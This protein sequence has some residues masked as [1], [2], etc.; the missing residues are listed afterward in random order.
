MTPTFTEGESNSRDREL[1]LSLNPES[2]T[3]QP[4]STL[5]CLLN[6]DSSGSLSGSYEYHIIISSNAVN[7]P[8]LVIPVSVTV[9]GTPANIPDAN[10]RLAINDALGQGPDYQPTVQDLESLT[11]DLSASLY[12]II[13]IEGAQHLVNLQVLYLYNNY[14]SDL[15]PL[16][17]LNNLWYL[18][19]GSNQISD[20]SPLGTVSNLQELLLDSNQISDLSPLAL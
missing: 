8:E 13:S 15:S 1:M 7:E 10:F 9:T 4:D 3:V 11:D 16:S 6:I 18:D 14:I 2:G 19:L 17:G 5:Y 12:D 20:L